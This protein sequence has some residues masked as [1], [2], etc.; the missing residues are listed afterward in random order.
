MA[1]KTNQHV[2]EDIDKHSLGA[3]LLLVHLD[4]LTGGL[5]CKP[6]K[7]TLL[8]AGTMNYFDDHNPEFSDSIRSCYEFFK[9]AWESL[10]IEKH[11]WMNNFIGSHKPS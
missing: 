10:R 8:R 2:P 6:C 4:S 9:L 7:P 5:L 3:Q 1:P 11:I